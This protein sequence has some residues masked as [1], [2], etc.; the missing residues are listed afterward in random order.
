[1]T[2]APSDADARFDRT[3]D[4]WFRDQITM[5]PEV[6]TFFG[7][8]EHDGELPSGGRDAVDEEVAF[9]SR[10]I[11][12]LS[13]IDASELSAE[14]ALLVGDRVG[15]A[16]DSTSRRSGGRRASGAEGHPP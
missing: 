8:H 14:R 1:M 12:E 13:A 9:F 11:D 5:H 4:R 3:I 10:T 2:L 16:V 7:L 15:H 6:A